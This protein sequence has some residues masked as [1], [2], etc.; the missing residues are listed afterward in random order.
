[1]LEVQGHSVWLS[2]KKAESDVVSPNSSAGTALHGECSSMTPLSTGSPGGQRVCQSSPQTRTLPREQVGEWIV[3]FGPGFSDLKVMY[4]YSFKKSNSTIGCKWKV[5]IPL[6]PICQEDSPEIIT[7]ISYTSMHIQEY[8]LI[9]YTWDHKKKTV[10][11]LAPPF[12]Q[13][14]LCISIYVVLPPCFSQLLYWLRSCNKPSD[15][16]GST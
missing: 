1:M 4:V 13:K 3:S 12:N 6:S 8:I 11:K 7:V 16:A 10:L 15:L 5:S 14:Y 2:G 9:F